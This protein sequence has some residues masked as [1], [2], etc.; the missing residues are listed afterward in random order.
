MFVYFYLF[1][2]SCYPTRVFSNRNLHC[3]LVKLK[4]IDVYF[5]NTILKSN[6]TLGYTLVGKESIMKDTF[7]IYMESFKVKVLFTKIKLRKNDCNEL[8]S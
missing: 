8:C 2:Y 3:I 1:K 4:Y 7:T 5:K 6:S